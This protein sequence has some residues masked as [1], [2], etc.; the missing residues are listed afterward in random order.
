MGGLTLGT[1]FC[2]VMTTEQQNCPEQIDHTLAALQILGFAREI[3]CDREPLNVFF[4]PCI[5]LYQ[6]K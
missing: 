6:K 5:H 2:S 4:S 3:A 1:G